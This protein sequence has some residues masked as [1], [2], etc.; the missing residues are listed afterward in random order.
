MGNPKIEKSDRWE[1][2]QER[3]RIKKHDEYPSL[4]LPPDLELKRNGVHRTDM[5][6]FPKPS[7]FP[8]DPSVHATLGFE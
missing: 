2:N 6:S 1:K 4:L 7:S 3:Q 5:Y 8:L